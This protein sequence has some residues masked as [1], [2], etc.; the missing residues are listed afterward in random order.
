VPP[1]VAGDPLEGGAAA[2]LAFDR[3]QRVVQGDGVALQLEVLQ[4]GRDIDGGHE[5]IVAAQV[6]R[7]GRPTGS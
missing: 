4:A 7:R 3:R 5:P 2:R 6:Q 1:L